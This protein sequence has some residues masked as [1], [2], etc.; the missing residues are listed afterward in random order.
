MTSSQLGCSSNAPTRCLG[1][2]AGSATTPRRRG[3]T[4]RYPWQHFNN[5]ATSTTPRPPAPLLLA[6]PPPESRSASVSWTKPTKPCLPAR[7]SS[8]RP[9]PI[10][11]RSADSVLDGDL[12]EFVAADLLGVRGKR[13]RGRGAGAP[14]P[15][16]VAH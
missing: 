9:P 2:E 7:S 6:D 3:R 8:S 14:D 5:G 10:P 4:W 16:S 15:T 13:R 11:S 12:H 1:R